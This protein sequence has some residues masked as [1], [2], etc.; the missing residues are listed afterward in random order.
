MRITT[1]CMTTILTGGL[2]TAYPAIAAQD[3]N[4]N[5]TTSASVQSGESEKQL[6]TASS[7][8]IG[9][10]NVA[11]L[12]LAYGMN[13]DASSHI[14]A[15]RQAISGLNNQVT[16]YSSNTPMTAGKLSYAKANGNT[17]YWIPVANDRFVVRTLDGDRLTSKNPGIDVSDAQIVHYNM[18][19]DTKVADA[20]L[21]KAQTAI[22]QKQYDVAMTALD[23]V[24]KGA[25]TE[26]VT[27]D[28]PLEAA[29][30]NLILSKEL[31]HDKDY[32]GASFALKHASKELAMVEKTHPDS[33]DNA[34][35]KDMQ[36][37]IDSLRVS[38]AKDD[39]SDLKIAEMKID[40]W[41]KDVKS[42]I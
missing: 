42:K 30:D 19:L 1:L 29:R 38:I 20:Q 12:D 17:D 22:S 21:V 16:P 4:G 41:I 14:D 28:R 34:H 36:S 13:D 32:H 6:Q 40:G 39:P 37:Q 11:D 18:V 27:E 26:T 31:L 33:S 23:N 24:S 10:I 3:N 15:A 35:I 8:I 5:M 25:I 9:N 7:K 2:L